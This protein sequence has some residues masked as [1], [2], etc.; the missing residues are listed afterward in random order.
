MNTVQ[1]YIKELRVGRRISQEELA[2][3]IGLSRRALIDWESGKTEG[4]KDAPLFRAIDTLRA[5]LHHVHYLATHP[6]ITIEQA[7]S[8]ARAWLQGDDILDA[9]IQDFATQIHQRGKVAEALA[10]IQELENDPSALDRLL[11]YGHGLVERR[12]E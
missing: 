1:A 8:L 3:I 5:G 9:E 4:I 12:N 11:G 10:L 7:V 2:D 6:E